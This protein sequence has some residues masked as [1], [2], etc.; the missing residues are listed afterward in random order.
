MPPP[1][2]PEAPSAP[3]EAPPA[4]PP[5]APEAPPA[6]PE[7]PPAPPAAPEAQPPAPEPPAPQSD[8]ERL[9]GDR[10]RQIL[11]EREK[12]RFLVQ[13][14]LEAA[15]AAS[16]NGQYA[17]AEA[18]LL[19]AREM[20][21]SNRDVEV[22]L[23]YVQ[24]LLSR[25]GA[26]A[27][28]AV[29]RLQREQRIRVD[30]QKTTAQL[31]YQLGVSAYGQGNWDLAVENLEQAL[32]II[33][34]SPPAYEVDWGTLQQDAEDA[35]ARAKA[36][37][38]EEGRTQRRAETERALGDLAEQ[39]EKDLMEE[40]QRLEQLMMSAIS[41]YGRDEFA[42]AEALSQQLLD[43]QPDNTKAQELMQ[44]ARDARH[45]QTA[46]ET[47]KMEQQ[48]FREWKDDMERMR[49][50]QSRI[51]HWPSPSMWLK[52]TRLRAGRTTQ[53][54][55]SK[56]NPEEA[57]LAQKLETTSVNLNV[58]GR[59]FKEVVQNL[60][61][62][63]GVNL[64]VDPRIVQEV[65]DTNVPPINVEGVSLKFALNLVAG[66]ADGVVWT[67][68]GNVVLFTKKEFVK[69]NLVLGVHPVADL[70]TGLTD[71]IPPRIDLVSADQVNDEEKPLFGGESEE[72]VKPYGS[73]DEVIELVKSSVGPAGTWELEGATIT[74]QGSSAIVVKHTEEIQRGVD[75]F[76]N[77]LRSFAGIV[78]TVQARFLEVSDNFLRDVGVDFRGLG[79]KT[80]GTLVNLDD[81]T[82][83]LEDKASAARDNSQPGL[84]AGA[85]LNP[86]SGAY[87][88]DG[89]DGD[90]RARTE[91]IFE[92]T[93]GTVLSSLGGAT[94]T[95]TY[96]DDT[97]L[98]AVVRAV[99]KTQ[100]VRTLTAPTITVYNTQRANLTVVNQLSYIQDYDVEV[101]Q[102][103]FI[104]DP[105]VGVI[106]DGL[107][108]DVR[109][110][111]SH[112][113]K[114]IT[115]ELQPTVA[116]L[117]EPIPTFATTLGS[118]FSTVLIQLPE[119]RL[120]SAK[121]TVRIP[122][123]GSIL[124]GGMK[125]IST[126][127]RQSEIPFLA[128]IP[129]LGALFSRK[130]RSDEISSLMILIRAEIT[131]LQEQEARYRGR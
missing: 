33:H 55:T 39:Q 27:E 36:A 53:F 125:N 98:A 80:P 28:G 106:Q 84:P 30:E 101:A 26:Q 113:R 105:I 47:T 3:P 99:E 22:E 51:L 115:L 44:R 122:D 117:K 65:G 88:N 77:D 126:M 35:L 82:N 19:Q 128:N 34:A 109:P 69:H 81:V 46:S 2:P 121:T 89:R 131:D 54:G 4:P 70:T 14:K 123:K 38:S 67:V 43:L 94:F 120:Q 119:L 86:S 87:F 56:S 76:L 130:G 79:G 32:F 12:A 40:Q 16:H 107:T 66:V 96:L 48:R 49:N 6:P 68:Q 21:P 1:A 75:K 114:Y 116:K 83:G 61:I 64:V 8:A 5:A 60:Q 29:D 31:R 62:Q 59:P 95:L 13:Q 45:E 18:L 57:A 41:A 97:Q 7:A 71:F 11:V 25:R 17:E 74:A 42:T 110:T 91:N 37:K 73:I 58:E 104:A 23:R 93:L 63:T 20:D 50:P 24:E 108:L 124:I 103:S 112:D 15:R 10:A 100:N 129:V 92:R 9:L 78:V 85:A 102:T 118:S 111:V 90:F 72:I 52:I 127:D